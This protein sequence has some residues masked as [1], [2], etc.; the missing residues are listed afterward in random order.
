MKQD[1]LICHPAQRAS[2]VILNEVL[3]LRVAKELSAFPRVRWLSE[4][5]LASLGMTEGEDCRE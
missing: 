5:F 2:I 1:R 3:V 4:R